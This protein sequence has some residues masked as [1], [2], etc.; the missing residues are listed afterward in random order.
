MF[1]A[2]AENLEQVGVKH[3]DRVARIDRHVDLTKRS[4]KESCPMQRSWN[5]TKRL[6]PYPLMRLQDGTG[7]VFGSVL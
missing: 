6:V 5:D 3:L 1:V 7:I 4:N 2:M